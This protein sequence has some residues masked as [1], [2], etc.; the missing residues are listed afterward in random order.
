[1]PKQL[2][3]ELPEQTQVTR[4]K[5]SDTTLIK[6]QAPYEITLEELY[7]N[8]KQSFT[9]S[10]ALFSKD[11]HH[12]PY[13]KQGA[14]TNF[15]FLP[16]KKFEQIGFSDIS[17][18]VICNMG[19]VGHGVFADRDFEPLECFILYSGLIFDKRKDKEEEKSDYSI[20]YTQDV[21]L[22]VDASKVGNISRFIQ[23]MPDN[24]ESSLE[25]K[26]N[27]LQL[28]DE[29]IGADKSFDKL[30]SDYWQWRNLEYKEITEADVS[31]ANLTYMS[32]PI[33]G[34]PCIVLFNT[35][36]IN[37]GEQ[38]GFSYGYYY[39]FLRNLKPELFDLNGSI[40]STAK[41]GYK[42][43]MVELPM[44]EI[45]NYL[46]PGYENK[47]VHR[48][49]TASMFK[50]D[51]ERRDEA[52]NPVWFSDLT[53]PVSIFK[54]REL[55]LNYNVIGHE[56]GAIEDEYLSSLR[57]ALPVEFN[58]KM[59]ER[60]P[61]KQSNKR[62]YDIVCSIDDLTMWGR[63]T[64]T[65]KMAPFFTRTNIPNKCLKLTQEIVFLDVK[66]INFNFSA[67]L[68]GLTIVNV[69]K[70]F[71]QNLPMP[72]GPAHKD[73]TIL[74]KAATEE[75]ISQI[76]FHNPGVTT[77]KIQK[78]Y[79]LVEHLGDSLSGQ[80]KLSAQQQMNEL[81]EMFSSYLTVNEFSEHNNAENEISLNKEIK[82]NDLTCT[83][84][85][86]ERSNSWKVFPQNRLTGEY[87]GHQLRFFN[88]KAD[89]SEKAQELTAHLQ[90]SGFA[91]KTSK[92]QSGPS[93]IVDL[94]TSMKM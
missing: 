81:V 65:L 4:V 3:I 47:A 28:N 41:Y 46:M 88:M 24:F 21:E 90:T 59:F 57:A 22:C 29:Q 83:F 1:M 8:V 13:Y 70:L 2:N 72:S 40:I 84:F 71:E 78:H 44:Q 55:L 73:K 11:K 25:F 85:R 49:Y 15:D 58:I 92:T 32:V 30:S 10:N 91:A 45:L 5:Y 53:E 42:E 12:A 94:T 16:F 80:R 36:K 51:L 43:I 60:T 54:L 35:Q 67:L 6:E 69:L 9:Y 50:R 56:F 66:H 63:F 20:R 18:F 61:H 89:E 62:T 93:I 79:Q 26:R 82:L 34:V 7:T 37:R 14:K 38:L 68:E 39:W 27:I 17:S 23:H 64:H 77:E 48:S 87:V 75:A 52:V 74:I 19:S 31:W 76:L 33:N 86:S